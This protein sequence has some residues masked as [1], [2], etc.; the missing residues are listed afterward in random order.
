MNENESCFLNS[1]N[2]AARTYL[3]LWLYFLPLPLFSP[4]TQPRKIRDFE[5]QQMWIQILAPRFK[6]LFPQKWH[7]ALPESWVP[8]ASLGRT[9]PPTDLSYKAFSSSSSPG[10]KSCGF[11]SFHILHIPWEPA[12]NAHVQILFTSCCKY[13]ANEPPPR[14]SAL[15]LD[16]PSCIL[17]V[18]RMIFLKHKT[19]R[20]WILSSSTKY[21]YD[22]EQ[23]PWILASIWLK[24]H[25]MG[26]KTLPPQ[27]A[28]IKIK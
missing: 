3:L 4:S 14:F 11:F 24:I 16:P 1:S 2:S 19:T 28:V 23:P 12:D 21:L 10:C 18:S 7:L 6:S 17:T 26:M 15:C 20:V 22:S 13:C 5:V 8:Q 25:K 27:K 9:P